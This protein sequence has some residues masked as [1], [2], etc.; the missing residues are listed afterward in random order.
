M[1]VACSS[2]T[3]AFKANL[4]F[5]MILTPWLLCMMCRSIQ[6]R[7]PASALRLAAASRVAMANPMFVERS[8]RPHSARGKSAAKSWR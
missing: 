4:L 8:E 1:T 2:G 7:G 6:I 3:F 5:P